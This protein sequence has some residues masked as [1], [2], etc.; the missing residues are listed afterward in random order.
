MTPNLNALAK[1]E[2]LSIE[3]ETLPVV[4]YAVLA[5]C[6]LGWLLIRR[7][8]DWKSVLLVGALLA[9]MGAFL[10]YPI[11]YAVIGAFRADDM[12]T[13]DFVVNI[14]KN[15]A[16]RE[17][18]VNSF[19]LGI[20]VTLG[21]TVLTLPLSY[22]ASRMSFRGRGILT[23]L[24]LVPMIMPPFVGAIGLRT[25]FA[26]FGTMN[27]L[28]QDAGM[29]SPESPV[30]WFGSAQFIGVAILE[31]LHLYPIMF[32]NVTA[33]L[34]N[35]DP[36]LEDAARNMGSGPWGVFRRVTFPLMMPGYFAGAIMVFIWAFTDLGTP[37]I[38]GLREVV[39]VRIFGYLSEINTSGEGYALVLLVLVMTLALF[40]VAKRLIGRMSYAMMSR[41]VAIPE[42]RRT[43]VLGTAI[44]WMAFGGLTL[45]A[46][47]PHIGVV[48]SSVADRWFATPL[49]S[50]YTLD[51][52]RNALGD[53]QTLPSIKNSLMLSVA[54][55]SLDIV[56]GVFVAWVLVRKR[57]ALSSVI[58]ALVMLPL[59]LPGIVLAFGYLGSFSG[60][61]KGSVWSLLDPTV[62]PMPLLAIAYGVR[63]L[64]YVVRSA[65][66]GFQQT[67]ETLEEAS[68]NLGAGPVRTITR[69]TLPLVAANLIA[70]AVLAF[71]FAMLEV[72]DSLILAQTPAHYPITKTIY[73][74]FNRI[75]EGPYIASA[76]GVWC[77]AFLALSLMVASQLMGKKMGQIFRA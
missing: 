66:A 60:L 5:A 71:S 18:I 77:M 34:A 72:S 27:L 36:S 12:A 69:I 53:R 8:R 13:T 40:L 43:G 28:L 30:D 59:A 75:G 35:V 50:E 46:L 49:P 64:P 24:L 39:P 4:A 10:V 38:F 31:I 26:R 33:A 52:F 41:A 47:L 48:L 17:S 25:M 32:L 62:N 76:L 58:D 14:F 44:V 29:M 3:V 11:G 22:V 61:E 57:F 56:I 68:L 37:L 19:V 42:E 74:L 2:F 45:I 15:R 55:T 7:T 20:V 65:V 23:A 73:D 54:A 51:H 67:S 70:G 16:L 63:R 1:S 21:T 6:Y 9:F